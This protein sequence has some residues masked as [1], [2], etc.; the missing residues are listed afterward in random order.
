M[1]L[2]EVWKKYKMIKWLF[3]NSF[4]PLSPV[5]VVW[6]LSWLSTSPDKSMFSII[7]DG[8]VFFYCAALISVALGEFDK[9]PSTFQYLDLW[10]MGFLFLLIF[11]CIA[12]TAA[13]H[14][15]S[16]INHKR[17][18]WIS[19]VT[20]VSATTSVLSFRIQATLI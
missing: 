15:S 6:L 8:Q 16:G 5:L 10:L 19:M 3:Y 20:A 14:D 7:K 2:L 12:F 4:L 13:A 11:S 1:S 9:V 17:Y 18:G